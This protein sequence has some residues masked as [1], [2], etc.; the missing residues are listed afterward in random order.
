MTHYP[1]MD[2]A[3]VIIDT[4]GLHVRD[5]GALASAIE[6]PGQVVWGVEAYPDLH[7][8][9]AALLDA[10]NRSHPLIDG[11]KRLSFLLMVRLYDL[12]GYDFLE[13]PAANDTFIRHQFGA[14]HLPLEAIASWLAHRVI[15]R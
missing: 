5:A 12:N 1:D 8:K 4:L 13:D 15:A 9:A 10:I 6:R 2:T 3:R 14:D 11:N 7:L